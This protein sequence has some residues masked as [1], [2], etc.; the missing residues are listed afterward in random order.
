MEVAGYQIGTELY[1]SKSTV[2]MRGVRLRDSARV[3]IK[4]LRSP[5]PAP[6]EVA[7]LRREYEIGSTLDLAG[8][9]EYHALEPCANGLALVMQDFDAVSLAAYVQDT[10]LSLLELLPI[11]IQLAGHLGDIHAR[12][13]IHKDIKP[14]NIVLNPNSNEVRFIDF[15]IST[16]LSRETSS[17]ATPT[18][19]EGT[20]AYISPEQ[21][22]RMNRTIDYRTD[23]Y[24]FGITLY[25]LL[26]GQLPFQTDDPMELVY[27]HIAREVPPPARDVSG[28]PIPTVI[29][30]IVLRLLAKTAEERY[31]SA[32]G[33]KHD[34]EECFKYLKANDIIN[35]NNYTIGQKD[36]SDIFLIPQKLYGREK[37]IYN[38]IH[39]FKDICAGGKQLLLVTGRSGVGKSALI[40]EIHKPIAATGGMF[41]TGKF[42]QFSRDVPYSAFIQA[43]HEA[44]RSILTESRVQIQI[45][46]DRL[47][48]AFGP[49]GQ[50]IIDV[51]PEVQH[52][53]GDQLAV[54]ELSPTEAQHRFNLVFQ[55]FMGA[56]ASRD[57][58]LVIFLDDMQWADASSFH[59][60][61]VLLTDPDRSHVLLIGAYRDNEVNETHPL[62]LTLEEIRLANAKISEINVQPLKI[63]D[64]YRL[65]IETLNLNVALE[66]IEEWVAEFSARIPGATASQDQK[67]FQSQI[68]PPAGSDLAELTFKKTD[69]NPFFINE[70]LRSLYQEHL[71]NFNHAGFQWTYDYAGIASRSITSDA[72]QF[73]TDR[74]NQLDEATLRIIKFCAVLGSSFDLYTLALLLDQ[75]LS[76]VLEALAP[77]MQ[78]GYIIAQNETYKYLTNI[79]E[80]VAGREAYFK[81]LHDRVQQAAYAL[82]DMHELREYHYNTG[83]VYLQ[84]FSEEER[85]E[86]LLDIVAHL[87]Q[88]RELIHEPDKRLELAR[89]NLKAGRKSRKATANES[90]VLFFHIGH[91]LLPPDAKKEHY[92]LW[93]AFQTELGETYYVL[94]ELA[95]ARPYFDNVLSSA[96]TG[97]E[98][99][100]IYEIMIA[101][102][103]GQGQLREALVIGLEALA[104]LGI[105]LPIEPSKTR[106]QTEMTR[107]RRKLKSRPVQSLLNLK[108]EV[109]AERN[110]I[111]RLLMN[112]C[113]PAFNL[114]SPLF[115]LIIA[116]MVN[117]SILSG[118]S[119]SSI[120]A[121]AAYGMLLSA[122]RDDVEAGIEFGRLALDLLE[123]M[124]ARELKGR[125]YYLYAATMLPWQSHILKCD[126]YLKD[127]YQAG[128][129]AGDLEYV[130]LCLFTM[131]S[132]HLWSGARRL[133]AIERSFEKYNNAIHKTGQ[134]QIIDLTMLSWQYILHMQG[135]ARKKTRMIGDR[136]DET[137]VESV[138]IEKN[139]H[140]GLFY[141]YFYKCLIA[142]L[143][144]DYT[145]ARD[146]ANKAQA[147]SNS[148]P[149]SYATAVLNFCEALTL[150]KIS[151]AQLT[152]Q[153]NEKTPLAAS[154]KFKPDE[155]FQILLNKLQ[156]RAENC[157]ENFSVF[158]HLLE[159]EL[160][161]LRGQ[162]GRAINLYDQAI[163]SAHENE[164][165][166]YEGLG[167]ELAGMY[168]LS[169]DKSRFARL[170]L[171]DA[172][173]AYSD[174]RAS[175]KASDLDLRHE[176]LLRNM[177]AG[178]PAAYARTEG[179]ASNMHPDSIQTSG[180]TIDPSITTTMTGSTGAMDMASIIKAS[181]AISSE[182]QLAGLLERLLRIVMENAGAQRG[183]L[184]LVNNDELLI[185]ARGSIREDRVHVLEGTP[186]EKSDALSP[187]IVNVVARTGETVVLADASAND[188]YARDAYIRENKPRSVLCAPIKKQG[189]ISGILYL[190]NNS[191]R[192]SFTR[193]RL[194]MLEM[195][196]AQIATSI[197]NAQL[198]ANL[199]QALEQERAARA[200]QVSLNKAASRFVPAQFLSLL[201]QDSLVDL[202]LGENIQRHMAVLFADI[203]AFT[204]L[205]ESML[206]EENFRFINSYLR[207]MGPIIS[208]HNGFIDKYIGDAIMAL[209]ENASEA[210]G[211]AVQMMQTLQQYNRDRHEEG[212]DPI[213]VGFGIHTGD[214]MLGIIGEQNRME[215]TVIS[216]TVNLASRMEGLTKIYGAPLIISGATLADIKSDE[217][218]SRLLGR[219]MVK[220]KTQPTDVFEILDGLPARQQRLKSE[221]R[222]NFQIAHGLYAS[223]E[224]TQASHLFA[225]IHASNP[226][227]LAAKVYVQRCLHYSRKGTPRNWEGIDLLRSK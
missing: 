51:I 53:V 184:I 217:F 146:F 103:T 25:E 42:D 129:E 60:L 207:R 154:Q 40:Q 32:Y 13:I 125:V 74:L 30:K 122:D 167:N 138:W 134:R 150:I 89:L 204:R 106:I 62:T 168:Y 203:R 45:W 91:D 14:Q 15:G 63:A 137:Q 92:E 143:F 148:V 78:S 2:V 34:L 199:E 127:A 113:L 151:A 29:Q 27:C 208:D 99:L 43:F 120:F 200:A 194:E 81:F 161:S 145:D 65:L 187:A 90:A 105:K 12:Q 153:G 76:D 192:G 88:G 67:E 41:L 19:L 73:M 165:T 11:L 6:E 58:P 215:G 52:I 23:L 159:A 7:R 77:A 136:F 179:V 68:T 155:R 82:L 10:E 227:D 3:L 116:R 64:V 16:R 124:E 59:L 163:K 174:C 130:A 220:G 85:E 189:K 57:H 79:S 117:M 46:K 38:L 182:L 118:N 171:R 95:R 139:N 104:H 141:L 211:A 223:A 87:N 221:A 212:Y 119:K 157:P 109:N 214:L 37:E 224:F 1:H 50:I 75:K 226:E 31:R 39:V 70:Y 8:V 132:L 149:G 55:K 97:I 44:V 190:E 61:R 80:K 128:L 205:S 169:L 54:P 140:T 176:L 173:T 17:G 225:E 47:V 56:F 86:R 28:N 4:F 114:S 93:I 96:R 201:G 108:I 100:R 185:Q 121:Y 84:H 206:P 98:R 160:A 158:T 49:N 20:L 197:E 209:F 110:A 71:I 210:V 69:G 123:K 111:M 162:H 21:T 198:Y 191:A 133:S 94:N 126:R 175:S 213:D 196:S 156:Y 202:Q 152:A 22:G 102:K 172:V 181:Q 193:D 48:K 35:L 24:S 131:N 144:A 26:S 5:H 222:K 164:L 115:P 66:S 218:T 178:E 9:I 170:Y 195:L 216:D 107:L 177:P 219:V 135:A 72:L 36:V 166:L 147:Y 18:Q 180:I 101:V 183:I 112:L 142:T 83:Y 186:I 188:E 33:L